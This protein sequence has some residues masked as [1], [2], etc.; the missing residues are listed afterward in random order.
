MNVDRKKQH[1]EQD[2]TN[3]H[4]YGLWGVSN[5]DRSRIN[6][7]AELFK[8][9]NSRIAIVTHNGQNLVMRKIFR[10]YGNN[11]LDIER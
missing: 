5:A 1:G 10:G 11:V 9:V 4:Q 6:M 2:F 3:S 8:Y 7:D